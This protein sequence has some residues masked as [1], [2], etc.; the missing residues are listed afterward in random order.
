MSVDSRLQA[1]VSGLQRIFGARLEAVVAYGPSNQP[2]PHCLALVTTL[3]FDDLSALATAA[4]TWHEA[5]VATPLVVPRDEFAASL[6]AF[7][8]EYGEIIDTHVPLH[9]DDPFAG[10]AID[11]GDLRRAV[12]VQA[13][14]LL[15][16]LRENFIEV[17]GT[18]TDTDRLVRESAPAFAALLRRM[19]RLDGAPAADTMALARWAT[20]RANLDPRIVGD[21]LNLADGAGDGVDAGRLFPGYLATVASVRQ[22]IDRW[23]I[24]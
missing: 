18:P 2:V 23:P 3:A 20:T 7:P 5:G 19:A 10:I 22:I 15:L 13:A 14:G 24:D 6:D 21:A 8:I 11:A 4:A 16:H 12:E 9:G 17:E 1:V